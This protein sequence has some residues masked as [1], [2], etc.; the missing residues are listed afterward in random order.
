MATRIHVGTR[1]PL[2]RAGGLHHY[3]EALAAGQREIG[4]SVVVLDRITRRGG[5]HVADGAADLLD[6]ASAPGSSVHLHFAQSALPLLRRGSWVAGA[7]RRVLHFHGPWFAEGRVQG[8]A[9]PRVAAKWL[10]E[11]AT[12]HRSGLRYAVASAAFGR[13]LHR[14]FRVPAG[15][16]RVVHPGVD[17]A[18]FRPPDGPD[19]TGAD[20]AAARSA[21]GL[22]A[23]GPLF[24][25]VRRLEPRMG[26]DVAL[27]A[28]RD[29]PDA[30]LAICGTGSLASRLAADAAELG[31]A[32]R[33]SFLGRVPDDTL[34]AVFR[35][36]DCS[37]VPT[38]ALEGFG[39]VVLE[40]F[41]CGT[42]VISTDSGGLVEAQ[43]PFA[44]DWTVAAASP[45]A[46]AGR[47]A[48][49]VREIG[50][51][52]AA[53]ARCARRRHAESRSVAEM[54]HRVDDLLR[55]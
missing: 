42:P 34:P 44:G 14:Y 19:R 20:R 26:L 29:V 3:I 32:A 28:L 40:S 50:T 33:V 16:I 54:A 53:D 8:D 35:A 52:A 41:A 21:L 37:L 2:S 49:V 13:L 15:R 12:Y 46:L 1:E 6:T 4:H 43:G 9:V 7:D 30:H 38:V 39:L 23:D 47:M 55:P 27:R 48:D 17:V 45:A 31:V 11:M 51:P 10:T 36:A 24:V 5:H 25:A 18:R 22:P